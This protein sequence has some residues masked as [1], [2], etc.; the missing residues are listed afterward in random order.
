MNVRPYTAADAD[1]LWELKRGFELGIGDETGGE[2]KGP[3][4]EA[5]LTDDYREK[6]LAWVDDC[7]AENDHCVT[8]AVDDD[9][10]VAG[11]VFVLPASLG[12]VWDAAVLNELFVAPEHRGTGVADDL[13]EAALT[14]AR[15]MELPLDRIVLDVDRE[16]DRAQAFYDRYGFEHWG[17]MVA[18]EL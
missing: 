13:M 3:K 16:N 6:W 18:R 4:Y 5:K 7:V 10:E 14:L 2:D 12:F 8:V 11:Y 17:E 1:G 15:G 9:G